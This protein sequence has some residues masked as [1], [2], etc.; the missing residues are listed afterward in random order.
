MK[1]QLLLAIDLGTTGNRAIL[2]D[3]DQN[4]VAKA[5]QE[6]PQYFPKPGWVEHDPEEIWES[7]CAVIAQVIAESKVD[8]SSIISAGITNQRETIV[9]W[10]KTTGKP[11]YNAIV[12]QCRRTADRCAKMKAEGAEP[13]IRQRTGL[14]L[15]P[16][17]SGTKLQWLLEKFPYKPEYICGTIDTWIL[18]KLTGGK[19]HATEP[20]NASRTLLMNLA[21]SEWDKDLLKFFGVPRE[22]LPLIR[23]SDSHFGDIDPKIFGAP[24]PICAILGDQ[25][26]SLF[27]QGC[28]APGMYKN[29]YGTGG[30]LLTNTGK[31]PI[32]S[33]NGLLSTV[34]WHT[35]GQTEYA[36][37]GS[38]FIAGAAI[39][40]LR[41]GLG[42][43]K[44]AAETEELMNALADN[45]G[46]YFVPALA[47]LGAPHWDPNARGMLIGLTRGTK[48]EHFVRA[49]LEALCYQT[50]DVLHAMEHDSGK[51]IKRLT[52]DGGACANNALMQFQ[53]DLLGVSVYRPEIIETT[54]LG[55]ALL[56]G[57]SVGVYKN[58][59]EAVR[60]RKV[61]R[62]FEPQR[63]AGEMAQ[64][65]VRWKEAVERAKGWEK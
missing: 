19:V 42:I 31:N 30:F 25:Q 20:G 16:Y 11:V 39:Q 36:L 15:D 46:V 29:T 1:N 64:F 59:D 26:A 33:K 45:E 4:I 5:Y 37:E 22:M 13:S 12:W 10:D 24:I 60:M 40:W 48:R 61:E 47:G 8:P 62:I 27:A 28:F 6:F 7:T 57:V 21:R 44:H 41:D 58:R 55:A 14:S 49:A 52:V 17:F 50:Q 53:A 51:T 23:P 54:A 56:S 32:F 3:K 65:S 18:W 38:V 9:I 2:F 34:A 35:N 63:S 43:I